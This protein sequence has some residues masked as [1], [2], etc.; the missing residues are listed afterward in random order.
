[1]QWAETQHDLGD[2]LRRLD[3][4]DSGTA[5]LEQAVA[6]YRA[7][8]TIRTGDRVPLLWARTENAL[9]STLP[10]LA[11]GRADPRG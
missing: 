8:L 6:A 7:A 9:G 2:A 5:H 10:T 4:R 11:G 3:E 1:M